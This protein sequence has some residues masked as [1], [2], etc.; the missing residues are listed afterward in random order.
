MFSN[1]LQRRL[2]KEAGIDIVSVHPGEVKTKVVRS[3]SLWEIWCRKWPW[4]LNDMME[5][6]VESFLIWQHPLKGPQVFR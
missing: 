2:I 4:C 5:D 3:A 1:L 6:Y